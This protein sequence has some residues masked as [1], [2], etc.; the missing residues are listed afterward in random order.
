MG[1]SNVRFILIEFY[2]LIP[3]TNAQQAQIR[4]TD[5]AGSTFE[6]GASDYEYFADGDAFG[7]SH[8]ETV[9]FIG[10]TDTNDW[11]STTSPSEGLSG[12]M[13]IIDAGNA[14]NFTVAVG[15]YQG[16][17]AGAATAIGRFAGRYNTASDI[18]GFQII[19]SSG[20]LS[21]TIYVYG[22]KRS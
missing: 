1:H 13:Y 22:I 5:D 11:G 6:Q 19:S 16:R 20:S 21:G 14:S 8:S 4:F 15:E 9:S 12:R 10:I 3:L 17:T 18:D 2:N 7:G